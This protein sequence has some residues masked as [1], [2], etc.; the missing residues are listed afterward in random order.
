L[1]ILI[2]R[3]LKDNRMRIGR[4]T[5]RRRPALH[6]LLG[7]ILWLAADP[8]VGGD[9]PQILGPMRDGKAQG[10]VLERWTGAAPPTLWQREVGEGFAGL[11]VVGERA[12]LFHRLGNE[13]VAE[14]L[15]SGTGKPLWK[16]TFPTRYA[17]GV[18]PDNGPRCVPLVHGGFVYL[19]GPGGELACLALDSGKQVWFR[20]VY[21]EF[22][23]PDGYFGAGSSPIVEGDKLLLNVGGTGGAGIVAFSL[24]D[25]KTVWK[26]TDEAASYSS[27]TAT[28]LGGVRHVVFV[29]R[30]NVVSLDPANGKVRFRF[31]FGMRGPTV[32]AANPLLLGDHLFVSA[33]YGV[34]AQWAKIGPK[35]ASVEWESDDVMSSQYTTCVEKDGVLYGID[36]RQDVGSA[37]FRAFD[38]RTKKV[39]WTEED[40]GTGNLILAGDKLLVMKTDGELLLV[41]ATQAAFR[42]LARA[43]LF[44]T[45]VQ[46]LP[47]L[48]GGRLFARDTLTLKCVQ[49][50]K[51]ATR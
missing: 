42:P 19:L 41:E 47:A 9:W 33:S 34:G 17:G 7:A 48:A 36:G 49:V 44:D 37:R 40:F 45:T 11:A 31:P 26:A 43:R 18:S 35:G 38:P 10:E 27:P 2:F 3:A 32:N 29:A 25:G 21:Q 1:R 16:A 12:V 6:L 28:T 30:L 4:T 20:Q 51:R 24:A 8:A 23:A 5:T 15:E 13:L 46:A 50:G 14:A 22:D 39:Y